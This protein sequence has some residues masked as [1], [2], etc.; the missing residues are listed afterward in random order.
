MGTVSIQKY[1]KKKREKKM[2]N[3]WQRSSDKNCIG[4]TNLMKQLFKNN[5]QN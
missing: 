5:K 3:K 2:K 4:L 1:Y